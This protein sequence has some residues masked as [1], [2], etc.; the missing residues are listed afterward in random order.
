M[1]RILWKILKVFKYY[2]IY[3]GICV[4]IGFGNKK[5][6]TILECYIWND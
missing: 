6:Y 2:C 1:K 5:D 4:L 3:C